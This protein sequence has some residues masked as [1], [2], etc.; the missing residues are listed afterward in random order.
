MKKEKEAEIY[1]NYRFM[2]KLLSEGKNVA[3]LTIGDP[4]YIVHTYI[5]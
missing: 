3:F 2:E 4:L 1:E 5:Y